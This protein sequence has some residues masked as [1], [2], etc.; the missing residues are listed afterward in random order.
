MLVNMETQD[1]RPGRRWLRLSL[2]AL[3]VLVLMIA[4]GLGWMVHRARVQREA[5][6]AI[7]AAGGMVWYDSEWHGG[8]IP[9]AKPWWP[10]WLVDRVGVDY[11][12]HVVRVAFTER[13]TD[14]ELLQVGHLRKLQE[15]YLRES[16]VT[17]AGLTQIKGLSSLR[18]LDLVRTPVTDAGLK[19]LKSLTRLEE[20][21]LGDT[22]IG[23][24]GLAHLKGLARLEML[25]LGNTRVTDTGL[26][27]LKGL[28][29]LVAL[30]LDNT[31]VTD[32]RVQEL[33]VALPK[34]I[35][36]R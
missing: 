11:F 34:A 10:R 30:V 33:Q 23:D 28:T 19:H 32:A 6:A 35:I 3:I 18:V 26:T 15:L 13:G 29:C 5:V 9:K 4:G 31:R 27:H 25:V 12:D 2:Q 20:L 8:F 24:A 36:F 1:Q 21:W 14:G 22:K 17:D 7:E 16:S